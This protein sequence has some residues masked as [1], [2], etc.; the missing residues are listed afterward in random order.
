MCQAHQLSA[1]FNKNIHPTSDA[2]TDY[3]FAQ[4][5]SLTNQS[6][7]TCTLTG[8]V[9]FTMVGENYICINPPPPF[10]PNCHPPD[11]SAHL[12]QKI[13]RLELGTPQLHIVHP[14]EHVSFS[15][16]W[17]PAVVPDCTTGWPVPYAIDL[18]ISGD[19]KTIPLQPVLIQ[20]CRGEVAITELGINV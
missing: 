16:L 10:P 9:D 3:M 2:I 12:D 6:S 14:G 20:P 15:V 7:S 19:Q 13:S 1:I 5:I 17:T 8:W 4:D 11:H 18:H